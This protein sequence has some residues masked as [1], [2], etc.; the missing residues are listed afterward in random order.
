MDSWTSD[1]METNQ[2]WITSDI[3]LDDYL[4]GSGR[5]ANIF[6]SFVTC[7]WKALRFYANLHSKFFQ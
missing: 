7:Y 6:D 2:E 4:M 5:V 1:K 3:A